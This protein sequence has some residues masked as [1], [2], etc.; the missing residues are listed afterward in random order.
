MIVE[1][2]RKY[3]VKYYAQIGRQSSESLPAMSEPYT[4]E[5]LVCD[6]VPRVGGVCQSVCPVENFE[7]SRFFAG[8]NDC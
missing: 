8:L 2:W 7:M 1:S 5:I 3:P 4:T 6:V